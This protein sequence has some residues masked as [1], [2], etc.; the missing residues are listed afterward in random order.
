M[1]LTPEQQQHFLASA[2]LEGV[3]YANRAPSFDKPLALKINKAR[4]RNLLEMLGHPAGEFGPG[5]W[6]CDYDDPEPLVCL[7]AELEAGVRF[8]SPPR[9]WLQNHPEGDEVPIRVETQ[10]FGIPCRLRR[11]KFGGPAYLDATF[12]G[13]PDQNLGSGEVEGELLTLEDEALPDPIDV[14]HLAD[15]AQDVPTASSLA[16][17]EFVP[18]VR[19]TW[20]VLGPNARL[21][22]A[23][24]KVAL[25]QLVSQLVANGC[26]N[27]LSRSTRERCKMLEGLLRLKQFASQYPYTR[28]MRSWP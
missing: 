1:L 13:P 8:A 15:D 16:P 27:A 20:Q 14:E 11:D 21:G 9:D 28:L 7:K 22:P 26:Y 19:T 10:R 5:Q 12:V 6:D 25:E 17:R 23:I 2:G 4:F 3:V 24:D 18:H